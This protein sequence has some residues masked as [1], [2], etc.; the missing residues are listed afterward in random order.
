MRTDGPRPLFVGVNVLEIYQCRDGGH[1]RNWESIGGGGLGF[2]DFRHRF[3]DCSR[4][5]KGNLHEVEREIA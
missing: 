1:A 3:L 4:N 5:C 2:P